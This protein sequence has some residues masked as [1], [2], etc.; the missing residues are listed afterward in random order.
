MAD[1][2]NPRALEKMA[3]GEDARLHSPSAGRNKAPLLDALRDVLPERAHV[4]EIA[5]GTGE[6][7]VHFC[8]ALPG[9]LWQPSEIAEEALA[10]I[11]AWR[12]ATGLANLAAPCTLDVTEKAWWKQVAGPID[13]V[14]SCNMLHISPSAV[15]PGLVEGA[16][17]LLGEGDLLVLYGPFSRGGVHNAASNEE[18]DRS[19]RARDPDWGVRD[20]DDISAYGAKA[21]LF[22]EREI[23][24]PANNRVLVYRRDAS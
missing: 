13:V 16:G 14:L 17:V 12:A 4:L 9:L 21:G 8:T 1:Q 19:L 3:T 24:M 18:F 10:S 23:A 6:H 22:F 15:G 20:M 11:A 2:K 7:A 5:S